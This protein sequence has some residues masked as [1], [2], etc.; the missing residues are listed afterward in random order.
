M[1]ENLNN[2]LD[3][4]LEKNVKRKK[5]K[6]KKEKTKIQ[7]AIKVIS[8]ILI[9]FVIL[10]VIILLS[11]F[12]YINNK[13]GKMQIE[14]IDE[15][16]LAISQMDKQMAKFRNIAILGTDTGSDSYATDT[17]TDCIIIASI[18]T[19]NNDVQLYSIYRDTYVEM[20]LDG[21]TKL[22]KINQ[23]YYNGIENT[24]KT[25][26]KNLDLNIT[27]FVMADFTAVADLV[28]AVG[29][30]EINIDSSELEYINGYI[31]N[32]HKVTGMSSAKVTKTGT[33]K[34]TG[35]QAVA[36]CRIRYTAGKDYKRTERMREVLQK[37]IEK[38][39]KLSIFEINN[40]LDKMLPQVKTNL[41]LN[42]IK[43]LIP[44]ALSFNIKETFG[45]PYRTKGILINGDFFGPA[46]T[47]ETN[48]KQLHEE[49][50]GQKDY[51]VTET[52]KAISDKI[53]KETGVTENTPSDV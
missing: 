31:D 8:I 10:I 25:I 9:I 51:K 15:S 29:G 36:Y 39:K 16:N 52:V 3:E 23:A 11:G 21:E 30:I 26:N 12:G 28:D 14:S 46:A 50:Y 5:N 22:N 1:D 49:V 48:V 33:Q 13:L 34:L 53:K 41:T 47:L 42:E 18:N 45:W 44:K 20:E 43:D 17:R 37:I 6:N 7:K 4:D 27:E 24:L 40:L 38:I 2:N 32:I 35:V 19:E